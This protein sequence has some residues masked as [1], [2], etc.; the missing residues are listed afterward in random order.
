MKFTKG[1]TVVTFDKMWYLQRAHAARYAAGSAE[2]PKLPQMSLMID[3]ILAQLRKG[4]I[5]GESDLVLNT[6][7]PRSYVFD[8]VR[9]DARNYK[10]ASEFIERNKY[11]FEAPDRTV[12]HESTP[13]LEIPFDKLEQVVSS[14]GHIPEDQWKAPVIRDAINGTVGTGPSKDIHNF[15]RWSLSAGAPGPGG[16]DTME[17]LGRLEVLSRLDVALEIMEEI[18]STDQ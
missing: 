2:D 16:G 17:I 3:P 13:T 12:L 7:E 11:F 15:F 14:I 5:L 9:A 8:L 18:S 6:H 10:T 4:K 1:N